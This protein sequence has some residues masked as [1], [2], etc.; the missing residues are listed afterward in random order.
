MK[1]CELLKMRMLQRIKASH[2]CLY[3]FREIQSRSSIN[4]NV[5]VETIVWPLAFC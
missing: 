1:P 4:S 2:K 3:L 5:S